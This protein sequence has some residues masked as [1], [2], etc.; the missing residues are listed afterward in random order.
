MNKKTVAIVGPTASGKTETAVML[1]ERLGGEVISCDSM[2]LY[3]KMNI[4]T[5]KPTKEEMRNIPH[6]MIDIVDPKDDYS[7]ADYAA[8][9]RKAIIEIQKKGR[10]PIFCGGTGL[11]LDSALGKNAFSPDISPKIRKELEGYSKDELFKRLKEVDPQSADEI[12]PNNVK[13]VMRA[14][15]VFLGTGIP[16]SEWDRRSKEAEPEFSAVFVGISYENREILYDRINLRVESMLRLGLV[17]EVK[18]LDLDRSSNAAQAI[19]YKEIYSYLDGKISYDEAVELLKKNTR[20][21]AKRQLTW[22]KREP[23]IKWFYKDTDENY[24]ENIVKYLEES[25]KNEETCQDEPKKD[26]KQ[27]INREFT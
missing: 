17:D 7:C 5:A 3:K 6:H 23:G 8:E 13:R 15:E 2:Q 18:T 10:L 20:N 11:Y 27:R 22:F 14:L 24:F 1:A 26:D 9:A 19:G 16:K 4:G 25:L 12:H 21:Y